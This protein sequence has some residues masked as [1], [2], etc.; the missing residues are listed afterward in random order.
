MSAPKPNPNLKFFLGIFIMFCGWV[1]CFDIFM[2]TF[3]IPFFLIGTFLIL[4]SPKKLLTK[5]IIIV[6]PIVL[7]FVGFELILYAI[8]KQTPVT[9]LIPET[10]TD[11]FRIVEGETNGVMPEE[12]NGRLI[13]KVPANGILLIQPHLNLKT[14][15]GDI[16]YYFVDSQNH[17]TRISGMKA[18]NVNV[19]FPAVLFKGVMSPPNLP[20]QSSNVPRPLDYL[21]DSFEVYP[22]S[23][24]DMLK[25]TT[26]GID[27]VRLN[28]EMRFDALT[29]SL[30][31][32]SRKLK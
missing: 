21:Y 7:W 9:I 31:K 6:I 20:G 30:V 32:I 27:T 4:T 28:D 13:L 3:G 22:A 24:P 11:E 23:F 19:K 1:I 2:L 18:L 12:E 5:I 14:E 26:D 10:Y 29:D 15:S 16:E 25:P 17:R 8:N